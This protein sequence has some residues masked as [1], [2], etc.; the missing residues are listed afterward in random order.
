MDENW[1]SIADAALRLR[2]SYNTLHRLALIGVVTAER[3]GGRW[4]ID[5]QSVEEYVAKLRQSGRAPGERSAI[6]A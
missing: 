2:V 1:I 3:I 5:R 4:R 6:G